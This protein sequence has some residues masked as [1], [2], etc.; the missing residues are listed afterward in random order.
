MLS[1]GMARAL[2]RGRRALRFRGGCRRG[3]KTSGAFAE[4]L[5][6]G[7]KHRGQTAPST[8]R[9]G[10]RRFLGRWC[11]PW[12]GVVSPRVFADSRRRACVLSSKPSQGCLVSVSEGQVGSW[13]GRAKGRFADKAYACLCRRLKKIRAA[14]PV[15]SSTQEPG[16]GRRGPAPELMSTIQFGAKPETYVCPVPTSS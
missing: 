10:I 4:V 3:A 15:A 1:R 9:R 5:A 16:S 8:R 11:S 13:C 14:S 6:A 7:R 2:G 12:D